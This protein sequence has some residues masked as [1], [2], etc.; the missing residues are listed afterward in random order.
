MYL[1]FRPRSDTLVRVV[2]LDLG[3]EMGIG[4]TNDIDVE[5]DKKAK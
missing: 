3:E 1:V 5:R 2:A 4:D